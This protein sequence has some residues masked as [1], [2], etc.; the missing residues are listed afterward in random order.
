MRRGLRLRILT[1][2]A[3]FLPIGLS[4][5]EPSPDLADSPKVED[6]DAQPNGP[7]R[8]P[9][10]DQDDE[11]DTPDDR[12]LL[13]NDPEPLA[14]DQLNLE[15]RSVDELLELLPRLPSPEDQ[16][17]V[18]EAVVRRQPDQRE[19]LVRLMQLT[20]TMGLGLLA[21]EGGREKSLPYLNR[22]AEVARMLLE[23]EASLSEKE[24]RY[25]GDVMYNK[26]CNLVLEGENAGAIE[27]LREALEL[28]FHDPVIWNDP[29]LNALSDQEEFQDLLEQYRTQISPPEPDT[30][31]GSAPCGP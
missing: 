9:G 15:E 11:S 14:L 31:E 19:A 21:E 18:L 17:R 6:P 28:G 20:Q 27:T 7:E 29:E 12:V 2:L 1:L 25:I 3:I 10:A 22:S 13:K 16:R 24:K 5:R 23:Q 30:T 8:P 26:A 4:C